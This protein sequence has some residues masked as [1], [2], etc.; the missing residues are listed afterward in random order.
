MTRP[1]CYNIPE[2]KSEQEALST[3][4]LQL[5]GE[6]FS[7]VT[8]AFGDN[9]I[10]YRVDVG[11][12]YES[13]QI[14]E[15]VFAG[16]FVDKSDGEVF[17]F[18]INQATNKVGYKSTGEFL[19]KKSLLLFLGIEVDSDAEEVDTIESSTSGL[20]P[21]DLLLEAINEEA[22]EAYQS[23]FA[24]KL[25]RDLDYLAALSAAMYHAGITIE[26]Q[27]LYTGLHSYAIKYAFNGLR[28]FSQSI[29]SLEGVEAG[30]AAVAWV[31]EH[32]FDFAAAVV[33]EFS[34]R[35]CVRFQE[36]MQAEDQEGIQQL[37]DLVEEALGMAMATTTDLIKTIVEADDYQDGDVQAALA[38][39][40]DEYCPVDNSEG[41]SA[42]ENARE[43]SAE[44]Q[45]VVNRSGCKEDLSMRE[46][47]LPS[48]ETIASEDGQLEVQQAEPLVESDSEDQ[49]TQDGERIFYVNVGEGPSRNWDDC[50]QFG[51]L[52]AGGG[53]KWS[54]QLEKIKIGDTV[55]AYL[56][57]Y[58]YVGIG[59]VT[60]TATPATKFIVN[61][62]PIKELSLINDT[63]RSIKRF[64]KE[65]G[66]Y[67][68][69]VDWQV[70]VARENAAWEANT[71]LFTTALVCASLRN[72]RHTIT[73]ANHS[74]LSN[75]MNGVSPA[76][77]DNEQTV[78]N[79]AALE[80][81]PCS[82][83]AV[84]A[85]DWL[86]GKITESLEEYE[87][88]D[89]HLEMLVTGNWE[90]EEE[91][92]HFFKAFSI[93]IAGTA[94]EN[95]G[96]SSATLFSRDISDDLLLSSPYSALWEKA[97]LT[98]SSLLNEKIDLCDEE[99]FTDIFVDE[100]PLIGLLPLAYAYERALH[101]QILH[102][103]FGRINPL[104]DL[105]ERF[106]GEFA[107]Y[108]GTGYFDGP[109]AD[110]EMAAMP[111]SKILCQMLE[112]W[113][114]HQQLW[115]PSLIN[116]ILSSEFCDYHVKG[117]IER[118]LAGAGASAD[119]S[120]DEWQDYFGEHWSTEEH[121]EILTRLSP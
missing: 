94:C 46:L 22:T 4:L 56:K 76:S 9:A 70:A 108:S 96:E 63:I 109:Y 97:V 23:P 98:N 106:L 86:E 42:V 59:K 99:G 29:G 37:K 113:Q 67:L 104:T 120:D 77:D 93:H 58:G 24:S 26:A 62:T 111:S 81:L 88:I 114:S 74:L 53:R 14:G 3:E 50:R 54:K 78:M 80:R 89:E 8:N 71:G 87:P 28:I 39:A 32:G 11:Q 1:F 85:M 33:K 75:S 100:I 41:Y 40:I 115:K 55:I 107:D 105:Q 60:S 116:V 82:L 38:S 21:F 68:I 73:F 119:G 61:G 20:R 112:D 52:A 31:Q 121:G 101:S 19:D 10:L 64:N 48:A 27:P 51:F 49:Q 69:G 16:Q 92:L 57:G 65:N 79:Q 83:N 84:E 6:V 25:R 102:G 118:V 15:L 117:N 103:G 44:W 45:E 36:S 5:L 66:E 18:E 30:D 7:G 35:R 95:S 91:F 17:N 72:Q 2:G 43:L 110:V 13:V 12:I 90:S 34:A 47:G